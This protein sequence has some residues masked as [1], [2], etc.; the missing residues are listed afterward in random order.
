ME[1]SIVELRSINKLEDVLTRTERIEPNIVRGDKIPSWD[2]ELIVYKSKDINK[3]NIM[4]NI[5]VQVKGH[6]KDN[7]DKDKIKHPL[8]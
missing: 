3:S 7:I 4:G 6:Q 5:R 1:K 8:N 2:G